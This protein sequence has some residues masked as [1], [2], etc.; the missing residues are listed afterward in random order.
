MNADGF[1]YVIRGV[2]SPNERSSADDGEQTAKRPSLR[3]ILA[4]ST[5]TEPARDDG[6]IFVSASA[7]LAQRYAHTA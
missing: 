1:D 4:D 2:V 5:G 3:A 6:G 7:P